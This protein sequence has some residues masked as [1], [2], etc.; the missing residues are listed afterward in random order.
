VIKIKRMQGRSFDKAPT[1]IR[2]RIVFPI[3]LFPL[4][5]LAMVGLLFEVEIKKPQS[6]VPRGLVGI[7]L[8]CG[9]GGNQKIKIAS[10]Y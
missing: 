8:I 9:G 1:I 5:L 10:G 2:N 3:Y 6:G 7:D 4:N